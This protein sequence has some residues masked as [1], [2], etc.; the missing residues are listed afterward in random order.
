MNINRKHR[1]WL[2]GAVKKNGTHLHTFAVSCV[3][4]KTIVLSRASPETERT[5]P[6][7]TETE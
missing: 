5:L 7:E 6:T 4:S 3:S 2:R 1:S